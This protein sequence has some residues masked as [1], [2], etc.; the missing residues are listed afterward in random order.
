MLNKAR[1]SDKEKY[2][3]WERKVFKPD[4]KTTITIKQAN[5]GTL[6]S[7]N[8]PYVSSKNPQNEL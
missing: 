5:N 8:S 6:H 3:P 1:L 2:E 4:M 7:M